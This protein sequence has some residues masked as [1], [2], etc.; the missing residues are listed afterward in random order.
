[1][2]LDFVTSVVSE[3]NEILIWFPNR[4]PALL[5]FYNQTVR[6]LSMD[7]LKELNEHNAQQ[8]VRF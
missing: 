1:M 5:V 7:Q 3:L 4:F 6:S 8:E 2:E